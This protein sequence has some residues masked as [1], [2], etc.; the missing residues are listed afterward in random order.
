MF[1]RAVRKYF[2]WSFSSRVLV[3]TLILTA[4][5]LVSFFVKGDF[6]RYFFPDETVYSHLS[7]IAT[8]I[9]TIK[10]T[11]FLDNSEILKYYIKT[12]NSKDNTIDI[13]LYGHHLNSLNLVLTSDYTLLSMSKTHD[14]ILGLVLL[15]VLLCVIILVTSLIYGFIINFV[16]IVLRYIYSHWFVQ[17]WPRFCGYFKNCFKKKKTVTQP[18]QIIEEETD[19]E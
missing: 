8:D 1:K 5:F 11:D 18:V 9:I 6:N 2:S 4:L 14:D 10:N 12:E 17:Y 13:T 15:F 3:V 19:T 7:T 16:L